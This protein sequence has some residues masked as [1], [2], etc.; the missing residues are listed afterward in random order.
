MDP[1]ANGSNVEL[2]CLQVSTLLGT[3]VLYC[4]FMSDIAFNAPCFVLLPTSISTLLQALLELLAV[5]FVCLIKG[6]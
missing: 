4:L 6:I 5:L 2:L 3:I 1:V